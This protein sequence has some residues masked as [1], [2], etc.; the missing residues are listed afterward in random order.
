MFTVLLALIFSS[1]Y[2]FIPLALYNVCLLLTKDKRINFSL[3]LPM[4]LYN[5]Y[6]LLVREWKTQ[7]QEYAMHVLQYITHNLIPDVYISLFICLALFVSSV[8]LLFLLALNPMYLL[9]TREQKRKLHKYY[10]YVVE[11]VSN[12]MSLL[13]FMSSSV[14]LALFL[15]SVYP[16]ILCALLTALHIPTPVSAAPTCLFACEEHDTNKKPSL[17]TYVIPHNPMGQTLWEAL[18]DQHG[19]PDTP[20]NKVGILQKVHNYIFKFGGGLVYTDLD[21]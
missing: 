18:G 12:S 20:Q 7:I 17:G 3:L 14:G 8:Y 9:L 6:L 21:N 2:L 15:S 19:V 10:T 4:A 16:L 5:I 11:L 1:I 13:L